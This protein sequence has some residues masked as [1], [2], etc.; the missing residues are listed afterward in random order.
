MRLPRRPASWWEGF[1]ERS[2]GPQDQQLVEESWGEKG[3]WLAGAL[4]GGVGG[5]VGGVV[6][7]PS[8]S[9]GLVWAYLACAPSLLQLLL[10]K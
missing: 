8:P 4:Q 6:P 3:F 5:V 9:P 1:R 2:E 10:T 7:R